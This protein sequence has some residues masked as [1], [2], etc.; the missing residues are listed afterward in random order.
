MVRK[1]LERQVGPRVC[2]E[3]LGPY[4]KS[5]GEAIEEF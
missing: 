1:K 3:D 2:D 5:N 4:P